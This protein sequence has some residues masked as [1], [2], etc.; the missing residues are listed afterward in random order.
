M[1]LVGP[2]QSNQ[3]WSWTAHLAVSDVVR[4]HF[5]SSG[6]PSFVA[7]TNILTITFLGATAAS[8]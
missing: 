8:L 3:F 1:G 6:T 5:T 4:V 2:G 7:G